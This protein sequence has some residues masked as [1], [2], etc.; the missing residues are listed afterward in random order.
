MFSSEVSFY[1]GVVALSRGDRNAFKDSMRLVTQAW[2]DP[3][4]EEDFFG[5][6]WWGE[7]F[8]L[9]RYEAASGRHD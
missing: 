2:L 9:A 6:L 4:L 8:F 1:R 3:E 5:R 7:L